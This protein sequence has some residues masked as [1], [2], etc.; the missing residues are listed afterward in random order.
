MLHRASGE[1]AQ[2]NGNECALVG[3]NDLA[4]GSLSTV[5]ELDAF[6]TNGIP[7]LPKAVRLA[8]GKVASLPGHFALAKCRRAVHG[9]TV[10]V[11]G[12]AVQI[13]L[14]HDVDEVVTSG[15]KLGAGNARSGDVNV[16]I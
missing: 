8:V 12:V 5:L 1:C 11:K 16:H 14:G 2:I 15:Y 10:P 3:S 9:P 4:R 7:H 6:A 13:A